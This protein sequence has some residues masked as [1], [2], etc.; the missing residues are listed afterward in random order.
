MVD[1]WTAVTIEPVS[2]MKTSNNDMMDST[3]T[4][5]SFTKQLIGNKNSF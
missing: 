3:F 4:S 2:K 5:G 1:R